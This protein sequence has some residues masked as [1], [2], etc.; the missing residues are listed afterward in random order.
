MSSVESPYGVLI[1][2]MIFIST[3]TYLVGLGAPTLLGNIPTKPP[4]PEAPNVLTILGWGIF[5]IGWFISILAIT[6]LTYPALGIFITAISVAVFYMITRLAR[7]G[8]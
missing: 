1:F 2:Y 8:G 4:Y 6:S 5:N 7:G 3:L